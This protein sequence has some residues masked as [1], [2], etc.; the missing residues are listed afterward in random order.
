MATRK[1]LVRVAVLTAVALMSA[2]GCGGAKA[3]AP[4]VG[5]SASFAG[6]VQ[7]PNDCNSGPTT[8]GGT[9]TYAVEKPINGW[10]LAD[11]DANSFESTQVLAGVLPS[12]FIA[13]PDLS[14]RVNSD[15]LVSA[16][17]TATS[18]QTVVYRIQSRAVWDD[19]TPISGDDFA[20]AW[21][22]QNGK[23]CPDCSAASTA[24]YD[25]IASLSQSDGGKTVTVTFQPTFADWKSL[26]TSLYPAHVARAH[27]ALAASWKWFNANPPTFSGGPYKISGYEPDVAVTE[28]PNPRWYGKVQPALDR[29]VFRIITDQTA[30]LSA[31]RNNEVQA[32]YPRPTA[33]LVNSVKAEPSV[34]Y[35]VGKGLS[36][37]HLDLN[38]KNPLLS[39][40]QLRRAVFTAIDRKAIIS[41]TVGQV[42]ADTPALGSH[43]F[44]PGQPSYRDVVTPTGQG[45]GDVAKARKLLT[46]AGYRDVGSA[47]KT[48]AGA[49]VTLRVTYAAGNSMRAQIA[50]LIQG[51]L[52]QL[53]ITVKIVPVTDF[54]TALTG[55]DF[56]LILFAWTGNPFPVGNALQSWA[57]DGGGNFGGWQNDASDRLLRQAATETDAAKAA[58]LLNQAD[59]IMAGDAY[60]LPLFQN[61]TLLAVNGRF[62]NIRDNATSFGPTYNVQEWGPR[63]R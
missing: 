40:G 46:D 18:P 11:A 5:G 16:E 53:G 41:K 33:D 36:W 4:A 43:N 2:A 32:I 23:D 54:G 29:L 44:V 25:Q 59:Q 38:L 9:L 37:E 13:Y 20:Y 10:N 35:T 62:A 57:S 3:N 28:V 58:D 19:G 21:Q 48:P 22:T 12:A 30:E 45:A 49:P 63:K 42:L 14:V 8:R 39:D 1:H 52:G 34:Q 27:G 17:Q 56:D 26:F 6:C 24:G 50:E 61:P 55:G 31:L 60:V 47:L 7:H 15:L 51:Q